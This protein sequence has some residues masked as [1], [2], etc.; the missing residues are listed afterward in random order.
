MVFFFK[1]KTAYEMRIS[2]WSSDVC[3][4][5][6][7]AVELE[8]EVRLDVA[9]LVALVVVRAQR[10]LDRVDE[11]AD[12]PVLVQIRDRVQILQDVPAQLLQAPLRRRGTGDGRI[13]TGAEQR[14]DLRGES[15]IVGERPPP[16]SLREGDATLPQNLAVA[17][18]PRHP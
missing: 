8:R 11:A 10:R 16:V 2:D 12:D 3:S 5:D 7:L 13:E 6:L 1:Q 18:R 9:V 15:R 17:R 4:S 14:D